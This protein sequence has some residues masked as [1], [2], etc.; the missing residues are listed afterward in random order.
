ME[1]EKIILEVPSKALHVEHAQCPR[2]HSLMDATVPISGHPSVKVVIQYGSIRGNIH[3]D[4]GYMTIDPVA[5]KRA[6]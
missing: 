3:L 1:K 6:V 4:G 2:G 5:D